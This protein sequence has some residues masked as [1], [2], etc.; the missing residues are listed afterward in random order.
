MDGIVLLLF[1]V[2]IVCTS[3]TWNLEK[4]SSV[5]TTLEEGECGNLFENNVS[6]VCGEEVWGHGKGCCDV[7]VICSMPYLCFHLGPKMASLT[8]LLQYL[9]ISSPSDAS[10][11][12]ACFPHA[13]FLSDCNFWG[14]ILLICTST[15]FLFEC[16]YLELWTDDPTDGSADT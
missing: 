7:S 10:S 4:Y 3:N 2:I 15:F 13:V 11:S 16:E 5:V 12:A 6:A 14:L 8:I 9:A 1:P